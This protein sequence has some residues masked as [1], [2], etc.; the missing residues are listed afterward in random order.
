MKIS[1]NKVGQNVNI[2]DA[3]KADRA[4]KAKS[5]PGASGTATESKSANFFNPSSG[6]SLDL[7]DRAREAKQIKELAMAT[8][9]V[10]EAKVAKF[11]KLIADGQYK[12][13][14]QALAEKMLK[15]YSE[16]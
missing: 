10:D 11:K 6:V 15:E 14:S 5:E 1:H 2:S 7:S 4:Q 8:P 13:D 16:E 12:V 9:D 3:G